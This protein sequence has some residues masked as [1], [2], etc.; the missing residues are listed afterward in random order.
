VFDE[1]DPYASFDG[2]L[3][4]RLVSVSAK[5]GKK[6]AERT[7]DS[8]P[9]FDGMIAAGGRLLVALEDGSLVCLTGDGR[10]GGE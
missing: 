2:R 7:L 9:V 6:L 5:D 8:P 10:P 3:G 1:K 4:A